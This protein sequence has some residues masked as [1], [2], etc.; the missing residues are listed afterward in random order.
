MPVGAPLLR[1]DFVSQIEP[2]RSS[3]Q[4]IIP[5]G[6]CIRAKATFIPVKS[7]SSSLGWNLDLWSKVEN[8]GARSGFRRPSQ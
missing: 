4:L 2:T 5:R 6:A 8:W 1:V 3:R 7:R